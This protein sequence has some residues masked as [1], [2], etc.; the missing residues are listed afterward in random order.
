MPEKTRTALSVKE[1]HSALNVTLS[2][3]NHMGFRNFL[4]DLLLEPRDPFRK[5]T[6]RQPKRWASVLVGVVLLSLVVLYYAH[7]R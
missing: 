6:R 4:A 5:G 7:L 1:V 3:R 2:Q